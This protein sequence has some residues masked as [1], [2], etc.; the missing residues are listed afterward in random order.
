MVI[1]SFGLRRW[2]ELA[3]DRALPSVVDQAPVRI[4]HS[5]RT[6]SVGACRNLAVDHYDVRG[7][8]CFLDPDDELAPG[9]FDA[10]PDVPTP[11]LIAPALQVVRRGHAT[12]PKLLNGRD[13]HDLNPCVIGTLIHR[14]TFDRVGRFWDERAWED[15]SLF[16]RVVLAGGTVHFNPRAVYRAHESI[17]GRNL[18]V[19]NPAGL[20]SEILAS[21]ERW[22]ND[23]PARHH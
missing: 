2:H 16:R 3:V 22:L 13:I 4:F 7:W 10:M 1:S 14:D 15:W 17:A 8:M 5:D 9:Y 6:M 18:T 11:D 12:P 23:R 21:H 19:K 20:R